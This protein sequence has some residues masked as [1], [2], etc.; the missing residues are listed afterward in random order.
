MAN[1][2]GQSNPRSVLLLLLTSGFFLAGLLFDYMPLIVNSQI[3]RTMELATN[4]EI[5]SIWSKPPI[6]VHSYYWLYDALN[7]K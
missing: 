1:R 3:K 7:V 2:N 6:D 5:Q 4:E